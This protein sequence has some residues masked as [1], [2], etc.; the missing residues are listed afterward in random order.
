VPLDR[1][2]HVNFLKDNSKRLDDF[3]AS[4][5]RSNFNKFKLSGTVEARS[6][7]LEFENLVVGR[8][9]VGTI[10]KSKDLTSHSSE[11]I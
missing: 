7:N 2:W 4:V 5:T 11:L 6:N 1:G 9:D 10:L 3:L 8:T